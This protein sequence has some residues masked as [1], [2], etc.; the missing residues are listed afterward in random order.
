MQ[1]RVINTLSNLKNK[2]TVHDCF[3]EEKNI[4]FT[5]TDK[6]IY[7]QSESKLQ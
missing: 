4:S 7:D 2:A 5:C 6:A 3:E 1:H